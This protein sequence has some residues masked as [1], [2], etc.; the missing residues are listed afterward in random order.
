MT[1]GDKKQKH[2]SLQSVTLLV[3]YLCYCL[4]ILNS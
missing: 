2:E 4:W 1:P 3:P